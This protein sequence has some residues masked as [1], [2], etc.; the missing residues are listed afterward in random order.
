M[1]CRIEAHPGG[2]QVPG[3]KIRFMPLVTFVLAVATIGGCQ[4]TQQMLAADDGPAIQAAVNRGRWELECPAATGTV[5]S[6]TMLQPILWG[7]IER[8]EYQIGV[9][10]C[11]KRATYVVVCPQDSS[12]CLATGNRDSMSEN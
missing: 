3:T 2:I 12:G 6:S 5:L 1:V 8:A 7:G 4:T 10:G 9:S 11:G